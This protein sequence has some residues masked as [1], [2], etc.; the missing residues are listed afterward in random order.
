MSLATDYGLDIT[1][2]VLGSLATFEDERYFTRTDS[3]LTW[4]LKDDLDRYAEMIKRG[5]V[6]V[7]IETGTK[8]GGSALW[9]EAQGVD[10]ITID[11][12]GSNSKKRA[13]KVAKR[14]IWLESDSRDKWVAEHVSDLL[15]A[16]SNPRVL[17][18]LDAE[19]RFS[20]VFSEIEIWSPFVS[21]GSYLVVEDGIFDLAPTHEMKA[22]GGLRIPEEGG[23]LKAID[24][25][26]IDLIDRGFNRARDIE[27][28]SSLT[29]HPV[30][31]WRFD[32]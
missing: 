31:F 3:V 6:Q 7:V 19:H 14:T 13:R 4:K 29:H 17:V 24:R 12:D 10:V 20:H 8:W 18:S 23:P 32:G 26:A 1:T 25:A 5:D 27:N 11:I 21:R 30:G 22:R 2:D 28:M 16:R 15:L 9:F